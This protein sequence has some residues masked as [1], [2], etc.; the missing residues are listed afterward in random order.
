[1]KEET[2][3]MIGRITVA[4]IY[5]LGIGLGLGLFFLALGE[6]FHFADWLAKTTGMNTMLAIMLTIIGVGL[7][8]AILGAV[9]ELIKILAIY[10]I[11]KH[12]Q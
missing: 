12:N 9:Y 1:M 3:G 4:V 8:L 6:G 10:F 5:I 7:L 2:Y 11:N